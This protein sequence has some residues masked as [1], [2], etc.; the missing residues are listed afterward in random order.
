MRF[1][2]KT[3]TFVVLAIIFMSILRVE[4]EILFGIDLS[5]VWL[6]VMSAAIALYFGRFQKGSRSFKAIK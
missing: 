3:S 5:Y 2:A 6:G 1:H 4:A